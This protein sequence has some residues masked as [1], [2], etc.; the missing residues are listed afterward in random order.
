MKEA[1]PR[2]SSHT[3]GQ[4]EQ[5]DEVRRWPSG[6]P[7]QSR[8]CNRLA[9]P[10]AGGMAPAPSRHTPRT[11]LDAT[12]AEPRPVARVAD[13]RGTGG[14]V[15]VG[16]TGRVRQRTPVHRQKTR[17]SK[18][19]L[20]RS[21]SCQQS[22][23]VAPSTRIWRA[24][25]SRHGC[26]SRKPSGVPGRPCRA[27]TTPHGRQYNETGPKCKG[28]GENLCKSVVLTSAADSPYL[29]QIG[30]RCV[31]AGLIRQ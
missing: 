28:S 29:S 24:S 20:G 27:D 5:R 14:T 22:S 10:G 4:P 9:D 31:L 2:A 1:Q 7:C 6:A 26:D 15:V 13:S 25:R 11:G 30:A 21:A 8:C 23:R 16:S 3:A 18:R 19:N 12:L 17:N